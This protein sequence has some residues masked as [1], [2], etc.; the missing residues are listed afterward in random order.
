MRE[1]EES[2]DLSCSGFAPQLSSRWSSQGSSLFN[3]RQRSDVSTAGGVPRGN[4]SMYSRSNTDSKSQGSFVSD[5]PSTAPRKQTLV[6]NDERIVRTETIDEFSTFSAQQQAFRGQM[7][8]L[9]DLV[10]P[11]LSSHKGPRVPVG[12]PRSNPVSGLQTKVDGKNL[13]GARKSDTY[14]MYLALIDREKKTNT[15][16]GLIPEMMGKFY[17]QAIKAVEVITSEFF[18][19]SEL[20]TLKPLDGMETRGSAEPD[21]MDGGDQADSLKVLYKNRFKKKKRNNLS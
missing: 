15:P 18:L 20:K 8:M 21:L 7:M 17:Q 6:D 1:S 10:R 4:R 9:E 14:D 3:N 11:P 5:W 19:P 2:C 12:S 16:S 13:S